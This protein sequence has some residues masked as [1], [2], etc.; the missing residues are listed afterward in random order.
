MLGVAYEFVEVENVKE[1]EIWGEK[2]KNSRNPRMTYIGR[3]LGSEAMRGRRVSD[4]WKRNG[5][6]RTAGS[7]GGRLRL[8]HTSVQWEEDTHAKG[9]P[10]GICGVSHARLSASY[11][12]S[13]A[14]QSEGAT[15]GFG[16]ISSRHV[17][18]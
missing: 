8:D 1:N 18:G 6:F 2:C 9:C 4:S 5:S 10:R 17:R 11:W 15:Q 7:Q 14:V 3:S 13:A 16:P 12:T